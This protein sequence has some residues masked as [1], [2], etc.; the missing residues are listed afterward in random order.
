MTLVQRVLALGFATSVTMRAL[1]FFADWLDEQDQPVLAQQLRDARLH[2]K[3][4]G[5]R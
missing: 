5:P 1:E 2:V 3:L 4:G